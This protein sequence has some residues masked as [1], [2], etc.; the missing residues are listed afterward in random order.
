MGRIG[1]IVVGSLMLFAAAPAAAQGPA[2]NTYGGAGGVIGEVAPPAATPPV[3]QV[4][5]EQPVPQG[6][7]L[8]EEVPAEEGAPTQNVAGIVEDEPGVTAR[9]R[10]QG[11][12]LPFTGLDIGLLVSGGLLLL[13][14]G[15]GMRRLSRTLA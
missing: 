12:A 11:G 14:M 4:Q 8:P 1:M 3:Q 2:Q 7:V 6:E 5:G 15:V 10:E 9:G 13:A